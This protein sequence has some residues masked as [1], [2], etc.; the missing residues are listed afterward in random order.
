LR[1][2]AQMWSSLTTHRSAAI[3]ANDNIE[4]VIHFC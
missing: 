3:G 1:V 2:T 4:G